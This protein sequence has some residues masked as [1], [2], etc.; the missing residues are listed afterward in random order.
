MSAQTSYYVKCAYHLLLSAMELGYA[1][2]GYPLPDIG[3]PFEFWYHTDF[4]FDEIK[5]VCYSDSALRLVVESEEFQLCPEDEDPDPFPPP[6]PPSQPEDVPP[7][8]SLGE[9]NTPVS[10]PYQEPDDGGGTVP[11]PGDDVYVPPPEVAVYRVAVDL[12]VDG[13]PVDTAYTRPFNSPDGVPTIVSAI[14]GGSGY[15]V[16]T[17]NI[18]GVGNLLIGATSFKEDC[19]DGFGSSSGSL[20][21]ATA[22]VETSTCPLPD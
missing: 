17:V 2:L 4:A 10:P 22:R 3:N 8:T 14:P 15:I 7:G 16:V 1:G 13:S 12:I 6:P 20:S 19:S 9:E 21:A 18:P 11:Y 5:I